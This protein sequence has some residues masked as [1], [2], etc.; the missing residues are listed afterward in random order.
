FQPVRM[1][2][3]FQ[4]LRAGN[5]FGNFAHGTASPIMVRPSL[6]NHKRIFA[7]IS[8]QF[9]GPATPPRNRPVPPPPP[10]VFP[11][12]PPPIADRPGPV[13]HI[14]PAP[15]RTH[16][17]ARHRHEKSPA[18]A[19]SRR[20]SG[21]SGFPPSFARRP[22]RRTPRAPPPHRPARDRK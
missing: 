3:S 21:N 6:Y 15:H 16:A 19:A 13:A 7:N 2:Q 12:P 10:S 8:L 17:A 11:P 9:I 14:R 20:R 1:G 5:D 18:R 4:R 22:L